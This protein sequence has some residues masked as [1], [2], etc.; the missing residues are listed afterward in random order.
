MKTK[1]LTCAHLIYK[2]L[3]L[4]PRLQMSLIKNQ[5][6]G[7]SIK[8]SENNFNCVRLIAALL[9]VYFH[10]GQDSLSQFLMPLANIGQIAVGVFFF[11]SGI[12]V[13]QSWLN[14]PYVF[15]F[16]LKRFARIFP[17]L[18]V[19]VTLTTLIAVA[20]FSKQGLSGLLDLSTWKYI[21]NNIFL[22]FF[23]RNIS[24][25]TLEIP[26]VYDYLTIR[27]MNGPLWTLFWE[28]RLYVMLA[29]F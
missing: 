27:A 3:S 5:L 29:L 18:A 6:L 17:G 22:H 16:I 7:E 11:L 4:F 25:D 24:L 9:V 23:Q 10:I 12:F 2:S 15:A 8:S 1:P 26:G 21:I 13:L 19:C 28:G 14:T 20:F